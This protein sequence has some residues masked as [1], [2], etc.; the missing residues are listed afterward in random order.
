MAD[1]G[2]ALCEGSG[3]CL[4][5]HPPLSSQRR[6]LVRTHHYHLRSRVL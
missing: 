4:S 6:T 2:L 3:A 1:R 5:P